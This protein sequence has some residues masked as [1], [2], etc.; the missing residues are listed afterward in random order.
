[1]GLPSPDKGIQS[2][3]VIAGMKSSVRQFFGTNLASARGILSTGYKTSRGMGRGALSSSYYAAKG[4][5]GLGAGTGMSGREMLG[6]W[7]HFMSLGPGGSPEYTKFA[8]GAFRGRQLGV[9]GAAVG[10]GLGI[11][12]ATGYSMFD[13]AQAIGGGVVAGRWANRMMGAGPRGGLGKFGIGAAAIAGG[14]GGQ[15]MDWK[16]WGA[17]SAGYWGARGLQR[18]GDRSSG[19]FLGRFGKGGGVGRAAGMLAGLGA[20]YLISN[21]L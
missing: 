21:V 1:M 2:P 15:A 8:Q 20:E 19:A 5:L 13:Q 3:G 17:A 6:S 9:A 14:L 4:F 10:L 12:V 18:L 7:G 11:S 16:Q